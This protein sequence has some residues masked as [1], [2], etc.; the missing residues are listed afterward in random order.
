MASADFSVPSADPR[1]EFLFGGD[2]ATPTRLAYGLVP[3]IQLLEDRGRGVEA[4]LAA[5]EIPRFALEEPS[6]RITLAQEL[7]F[8][9]GALAEIPDEPCVS[10]EVGRRF[11]LSM[12]GLLGLAAAC[13]ASMREALRIFLSYPSLVWG[14]LEV[15]FW[16]NDADEYLAFEPGHVAGELAGYYVERDMGALLAMFRNAVGP[17]V[18]P[19]AVFLR[20]LRPAQAAAYDDF[21]GCP[22]SFGAAADEMHFPQALW[23]AVPPQAN[24][25]SRRYFENQCQQLNESMQAPFRYADIVRGRLRHATPI[26]SLPA[27]ATALFITPR[28]LQRR[29]AAEGTGF[30]ELLQEVRE[31]R[32]QA[33]LRR[34]SLAIEEI[35]W[36]LGFNDRDAFSRAFRAWTGLSPSAFRRARRA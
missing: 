32:A 35:A 9:R 18:R 19:G 24:D 12:F 28:T 27:L 5:A 29:L 10:L 26:P 15:T 3:L 1:P 20:R 16:R 4:V 22:V 36:R 2:L 6:F 33:L 31:A 13:A 11:H 30:G 7:A 23:D 21:F 17:A 8:T 14:V 34:P 25:R